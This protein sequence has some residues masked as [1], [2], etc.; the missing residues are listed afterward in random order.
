MW[1]GNFIA[2]PGPLCFAVGGPPGRQWLGLGLA[3]PPGEHMFSEFEYLGGT[4][5]ALRLNSWGAREIRG[6]LA[7]PRVVL[8]PARDAHA[9]IG[10]YAD[11]LVASGL[12]T[13]PRRVAATWWERPIVCGWGHQSYQGDLFRIRSS[14]ER[15]PDNAV[16]TLCTQAT[17]R[18]IVERLDDR[19]ISWGTLVI[20]ARWFLAGGLK[21]VDTGRWPDLRGFVDAQHRQGR[22]VLLWWGPWDPDGVPEAEC[23]RYQPEAGLTRENRPGRM[24]KFGTPQPGRKLAI[25]I[26]LP[27]VRRRVRE[28]VR[29]LLSSDGFD[30][31][32]LKLDHVPRSP[33]RVR[34]GVPGGIRPPVRHRGDPVLPR[35]H[36]RGRQGSQAR[37]PRDRPVTHPVSGRRPRHAQAR[38]HL[39]RPRRL[40]GCG[41]GIPRQHGPPGRP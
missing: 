33:W 31:D 34:D 37:R 27:Q 6:E 9:A 13:R 16:Y 20:D 22:K 28:Q 24:A 17:Y 19:N 14:P 35:P 41:Y 23:I 40:S 30:A 8:V 12:A 11:I 18:D 38:R 1:G 7:T 26:T 2:N 29:L 21:N 15:P 25:D 3:V 39:F 10:R 36:L 5:F 32:G 4:D